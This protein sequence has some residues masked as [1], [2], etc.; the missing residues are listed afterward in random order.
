MM[1]ITSIPHIKRSSRSADIQFYS[2]WRI[3]NL[4]NDPCFLLH[5]CLVLASLLNFSDAE[6][7]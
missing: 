5:M 6:H 4:F 3:N 7:V 2:I 1:W